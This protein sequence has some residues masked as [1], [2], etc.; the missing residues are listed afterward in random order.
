MSTVDDILRFFQLTGKNKIAI[1]GK[2]PS[3]DS[4]DLAKLDDFFVINI[5]DSERAYAGDVGLFHLPW[6]EEFIAQDGG[7]CSF[8]VTS[9]AI[10]TPHT[11]VIEVPHLYENPDN[12]Q[13]LQERF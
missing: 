1:I 2:G 8:Y 7:K 5:N 13:P 3:L 4:V 11:S 12:K 9:R 6:V 10:N